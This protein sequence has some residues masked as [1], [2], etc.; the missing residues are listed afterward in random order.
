MCNDFCLSTATVVA[1]TGFKVRLY[2][3]GLSCFIGIFIASQSPQVVTHNNH[4]ENT[5]GALSVFTFV[6][7]ILL[8]KTLVI[9]N[10][11]GAVSVFTFVYPI[12]LTKPLVIQNTEGALSVF[13]FVY[14]ILLTKP[15]VIQNTEDAL[16]VFTFVYP[17][18]LTKPLVIQKVL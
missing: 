12:L 2:V 13:T 8:T 18:L 5:E 6:Y 4:W 15:L 3:H 17:I 7:H 1:R 14:P 10:T 9:Q 11:E 16:S